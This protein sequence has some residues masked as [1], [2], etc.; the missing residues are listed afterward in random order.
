MSLKFKNT[1]GVGVKKV[2]A[3]HTVQATAYFN[4]EEKYLKNFNIDYKF[5]YGDSVIGA[6]LNVKEPLE[7]DRQLEKVLSYQ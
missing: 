6:A 5:V 3:D 2:Y 4:Q 1:Y 7:E